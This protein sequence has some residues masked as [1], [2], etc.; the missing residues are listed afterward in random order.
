MKTLHLTLKKKWFDMISS[1]EKTEEYREI[2]KYWAARMLYKIPFP[3]SIGGFMS[4][5]RDIIEGDFECRR[6]KEATGS[7]PVFEDFKWVHFTNGYS[8]NS[9]FF[10]LPCVGLEV[11]EGKPEWG[12]EPGKKYFVIKLGDRINPTPKQ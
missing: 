5:W 4:P 12:A 7:A 8:P 11:R 1:G 10:R 6:W 9:P 2:K 3:S